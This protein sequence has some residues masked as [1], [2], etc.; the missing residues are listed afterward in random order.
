MRRLVARVSSLLFH[1]LRPAL[2]A[3]LFLTPPFGG[4][5]SLQFTFI[6]NESFLI[7]DGDTALLTDFP[8]A[9][10]AFG[11][12]SY[13]L[14]ALHLPDQ[15]LCLITH[16]HAD[17]FDA[18]LFRKTNFSIIAPPSVLAGLD[19]ARRIAFANEMTYKG[20][21]IRAFRTPHGEIEHYSYLV[22][23]HG[24]KLYFTG[25]TDDL[26]ELQRQTDLDVAFVTPWLLEAMQK[27]KLRIGA[28]QVVVYHHREGEN[29][30]RYQ[31]CRVPKQRESF[32]LPFAESAH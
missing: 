6:G 7:S 30:P 13:N 21:T 23:W 29:V 11:Y 5:N 26:A 1:L 17:H 18:T 9:S 24:R 2:C 25:D 10:G 8:Y 19:P 22:L 4:G 28:R 27:Q 14:G 12:M 32:E 20:V 15:G 31:N 3:T 16:G